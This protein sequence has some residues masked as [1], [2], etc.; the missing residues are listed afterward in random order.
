MFLDEFTAL[1]LSQAAAAG[2]QLI[3]FTIFAHF[4]ITAGRS[5]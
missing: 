5:T 3:L 1:L 4:V 2:M